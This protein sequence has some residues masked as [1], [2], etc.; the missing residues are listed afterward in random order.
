MG[1]DAAPLPEVEGAL[2][3]VRAGHAE[4]VL[5]GD[6]PRLR[7][8]LERLGAPG[9][10]ALRIQHASE[11]ITM[12]DPPAQAAKAK[13]DSSMRIAF[14]LV[15]RG[16]AKAVVS[17]GNS[18][19]VMACGLFVWGRTDGVDRPGIVTTFPTRRGA[20]ALVDMGANTECRPITLAH[21]AVLGAVYVRVLHQ[22]ARA[23][24]GLLSNGTEPGKGTDLTRGAHRLLDSVRGKSDFEFVG[25]I[26]GRDIFSG[27]V[28][29]VVTDGF[30]GNV[31]LKASEGVAQLLIDFLREEVLA[32]GRLG[33]LG[34]VLLKGPFTRLRTR[35]DYTEH[36][37]APLVGV[38]GNAVLCHGG[39][40]AKAI[41]NGIRI[42][43]GFG[44]NDLSGEVA[45]AI[46][47]H[48]PLWP[49]E[50]QQAS[51]TR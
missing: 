47:R 14:D 11:V 18:G 7:R 1:G 23:R 30:T 41:K 37:G 31:L 27:D 15:K 17:A 28:D 29:V 22:K 42:A 38:N 50:R 39:S 3:A 40:N 33:Q 26:E 49:D 19:A 24:V 32:A 21:F 4:V 9:H 51:G 35:L 25:Y 13:K 16:Q 5:V 10:P 48:A 34:A 2:D 6:E 43:A 45:R 8:E 20:C 46:A 44:K 12:A 36:G